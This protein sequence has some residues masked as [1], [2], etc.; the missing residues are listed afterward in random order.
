[1]AYLNTPIP[2]IDAYV[3][4]NFLR[5]QKDSFDKKFPCLIFGMTSIPG[6]APLF[7]FMMEDGGLWWRMPLHAF[8]WKLESDEQELDELVLWDSFSYHISITQYPYLKNKVVNFIS[9]RRINYKGRYLFTIDWAA[10]TDSGDTDYLFS[11]Y[12][13]QHKCGHLIKMDNG[14][15]AIQPNNR[16]RVHDPAFSIKSESIINRM[17]NNTLWTAERNHRWVTPDTDNMN[18]DHTDL[19][20]GESN[21][22]RSKY[23]NER[24]NEDTIQPPERTVRKA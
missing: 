6:Q 1:M 14:N 23:Y 15:F 7:H 16:F 24:L 2:I 22:E 13:S 4:G 20:M 12:P 5:D 10:S 21:E 11:E 8:C 9:R 3:R 19:D 17:Y 18:Y